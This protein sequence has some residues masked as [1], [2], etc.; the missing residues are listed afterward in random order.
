MYSCTVPMYHPG[1]H[2][3]ISIFND[4]YI[5]RIYRYGNCVPYDTSSLRRGIP[6]D[7][8]YTQNVDYVFIPRNRAGGDLEHFLDF[9]SDSELVFSFA[10]EICRDEVKLLICHYLLPP[11]GNPTVF[12]PPT[13]ICEDTCNYTRTLCPME[14][15]LV[16]Q[17]LEDRPIFAINGFTIINCSNTGEYLPPSH[18]CEDLGI[19]IRKC[20]TV[21]HDSNFFTSNTLV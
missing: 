18:C 14:W 21:H 16:G 7:D 2:P 15:E 4:I 11:C 13:S 10:P 5:T 19:E 1:F 8:L 9:V 6:C 17:F 12:E 20:I 3:E